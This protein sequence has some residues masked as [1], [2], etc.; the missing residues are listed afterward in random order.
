MLSQV[1]RAVGRQISVHHDVPRWHALVEPFVPIFL[2]VHG[3]ALLAG[4]DQVGVLEWSLIAL[5]ALL[6]VVG[7]AGWRSSLSLTVRAWALVGL[8]WAL[9][10]LGGGAA[11]F[12]TLWYFLISP[13]YALALRG[14]HA[15]AY[16]LVIGAIYLALGLFGNGD[17]TSDV[18]V[19]EGM[20]PTPVLWGRMAVITGTGLVV[21]GIAAA[22]RRTWEEAAAARSRLIASVSHE[23]RTP[24]TAVVGFTAEL[25]ARTVDSGDPEVTEFAQLGHAQATEVA[26]IVE[27]LLVAARSE[28]DEVKVSARPVDLR[29]EAETILDE[30]SQGLSIVPTIS[31][32]ATVVADPIRVRQILRNLVA[33]AVRHG[34]PN[35]QIDIDRQAG[36]GTVE[37]VDDGTGVP[38][39]VIAAMFQ[40]FQRGESQAGQPGSIGL[41]LWVSRTLAELMGGTVRHR[42]R[43]E[44]TVFSLELPLAGGVETEARP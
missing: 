22:Q 44:R 16:P 27:D 30:F 42:R 38:S 33:N 39:D 26:H 37:I 24:L 2:A 43:G 17:L 11:S 25:R 12:F 9:L 19:N 15:F 34:G 13:V 36:R 31:G 10:V 14:L 20:L 35:I 3:A 4:A 5:T 21:A 1:E 8:T 28:L 7:L 41:G 18:A 6:G 40:P 23:L 32:T 29:R